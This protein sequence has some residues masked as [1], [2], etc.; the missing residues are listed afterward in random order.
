MKKTILS[1]ALLVLSSSAAL[2]MRA[3]EGFKVY[4]CEHHMQP[5]DNYLLTEIAYNGKDTI[6][7]K[8]SN[9]ESDT[10]QYTYTGETTKEGLKVFSA[11]YNSGTILMP[12]NFPQEPMVKNEAQKYGLGPKD[13]LMIP[14]TCK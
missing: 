9:W 2:A 12:A 13:E 1:A 11:P 10:L 6:L 8:V 7:E 4:G 3:P 14:Y 5:S